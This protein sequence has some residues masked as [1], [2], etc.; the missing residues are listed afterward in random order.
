[1]LAPVTTDKMLGCGC[2]G[3][4]GAAG[5]V[6]AMFGPLFFFVDRASDEPAVDRISAITA[7]QADRGFDV[8]LGFADKSSMWVT[9]S[10]GGATWAKSDS[11]GHPGT[12]SYGNSQLECAKDDVCYLSQ[13]RSG[14]GVAGNVI[15]RLAPG[16]HT[17]KDEAV[18]GNE[19]WVRDLAVNPENSDQAVV[20]CSTTTI[21]YRTGKGHWLI[22]DLIE[23]GKSLR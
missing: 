8:E 1:M 12:Q 11:P 20:G 14:G 6:V 4:V 13:Q 23:L 16:D 22:L 19:C 2:L 18:F 21:A 7:D 15:D 3:L 17:W 9:T 5:V 10:D